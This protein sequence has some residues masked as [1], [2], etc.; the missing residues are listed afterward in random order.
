METDDI[1]RIRRYSR[2]IM[3]E[4]TIVGERLRETGLSVGLYYVL[5][6]ME[7]G[8]VTVTG[9]AGLLVLD[10]SNASRNLATLARD[11]LCVAEPVPGDKRRKQYVLTPSGSELLRSI[12]ESA[13]GLFA[14]YLRLLGPH[15]RTFALKG[16]RA[17]AKTLVYGR[18]QRDYQVRVVRRSD[19]E[20]VAAMLDSVAQADGGDAGDA[21]VIG[22]EPS[23]PVSDA[24]SG[25]GTRYWVVEYGGELVGGCG[26]GRLSG[27]TSLVCLLEHV[28]LLP[29]HRGRGLGR[30]MVREAVE[31]ARKCGYGSCYVEIPESQR[32]VEALFTKLG[33]VPTAAAI[34]DD[35]QA[36][37]DCVKLLKIL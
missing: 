3:R 15:E 28:C 6:E 16:L 7:H 10:K 19:D 13:D 20:A 27:A 26:A 23:G 33:F 32:G 2:C 29:A 36:D 22:G 35:D 31:Y 1:Q 8:P 24:Y 37:R 12:H 30:R 5:L 18:Q 14:D 34:G 17:W 9:V 4:L 25:P 11:G 21:C